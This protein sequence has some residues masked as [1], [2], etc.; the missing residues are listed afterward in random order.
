M[1]NNNNNN[2]KG[3]INS[4]IAIII[5]VI[6]ALIILYLFY[7]TIQKA[8]IME[9]TTDCNQQDMCIKEV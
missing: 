2:N 8:S 5:I 3:I 6:W 9:Y 7:N 1:N 4:Y